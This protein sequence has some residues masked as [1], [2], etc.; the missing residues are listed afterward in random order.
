MSTADHCRAMAEEA[1]RLASIVSYA[2]DKVRLR[3]QAASWRAKAL[4]LEASPV[5]APVVRRRPA[6]FGW[7]RLHR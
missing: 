5:A 2:R 7:V 4:A 1:D 3:E 6:I